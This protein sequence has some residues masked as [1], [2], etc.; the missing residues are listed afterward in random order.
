MIEGTLKCT[1]CSVPL[2][3]YIAYK[4]SPITNTFYAICPCGSES[5]RKTISGQV[6]L[7]GTS[8]YI[9]ENTETQTLSNYNPEE[10]SGT[11]IT[12]LKMRKI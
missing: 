6:C 1:K 11:L 8:D 12:I 5:F 9:I 4:P 2:V 7:S 3:N 10:K